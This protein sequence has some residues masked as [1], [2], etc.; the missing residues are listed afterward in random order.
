MKLRMSLY[1]LLVLL[2]GLL[3]ACA[4]MQAMKTD[5]NDLKD[6]SYETKKELKEMKAALDA[7]TGEMDRLKTQAEK[8]AE[9]DA[10]DAIKDSQ[11]EL[12]ARTS[13]LQSDVKDMRGKLDE[14][15]HSLELQKKEALK[16][17]EP[18]DST[19]LDTLDKSVKEL[20]ERLSTLE[21]AM[22]ESAVTPAK[23]YEAAYGLYTEKK[24][25]DSREEFGRFLKRF[26]EHKLA[27]NARFWLA[28]TYYAEKDFENAILAYEEMLKTYKDSPKAPAAMLK[29]AMAFL[30]TGDKRAARSILRELLEKHP[31]SEQAGPAK[32]K[33]EELK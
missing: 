33:L 9:A 5:I 21:T 15:S 10:L 1:A 19:R 20:G 16:A 25:P 27:G 12:Y 22:K 29:Q 24:Y 4:A 7:V 28:E 6:D 2:M 26:P 11:A 8:P 3:P 14:T 13:S 30:E 23:A 31:D 18:G 32:K 17:S